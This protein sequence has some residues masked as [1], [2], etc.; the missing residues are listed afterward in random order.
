MEH[1][2]FGGRESVFKRDDA[3]DL[4]FNEYGFTLVVS[5]MCIL[6]SFESLLNSHDSESFF[7]ILNCNTHS[8]PIF[9]KTSQ[10]SN[11]TGDC[12]S[13]CWNETQKKK[14]S[15]AAVPSEDTSAAT[16]ASSVTH[17]IIGTTRNQDM[18][19]SPSDPISN[20]SIPTETNNTVKEVQTPILKKKKKKASYKDMMASYTSKRKS[21]ADIEKEKELT[22][23]KVTGGGAFC[24][25]DKI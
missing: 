20:E 14:N 13:K 25:I 3:F 12:C 23:Q 7:Y 16:A 24:K 9:F 22:I 4:S 10:G 17:D 1:H 2:S 18:G 21:N 6:D 19:M 5:I 8:S 15:T 11:A